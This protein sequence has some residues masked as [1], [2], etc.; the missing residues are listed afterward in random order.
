M[1]RRVAHHDD[2]EPFK[3][4][5]VLHML[6]P[7]FPAVRKATAIYRLLVFVLRRTVEPKVADAV[8]RLKTNSVMQ[9]YDNESSDPRNRVIDLSYGRPVLFHRLLLAHFASEGTLA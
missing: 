5:H 2:E 1:R 6:D 3:G 4:G 9:Q 7:R 8:F